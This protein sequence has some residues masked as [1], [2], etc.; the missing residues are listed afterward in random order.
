MI[1][2]HRH[3][4]PLALAL[5]LAAGC[6]GPTPVA[7]VQLEQLAELR[8]SHEAFVH[9]H[10]DG[11]ERELERFLDDEWLP[12]F[13][14]LSLPSEEERLEMRRL[15]TLMLAER[16]D[17]LARIDEDARW[18][19]A[20]REAVGHSIERTA[21]ESSRE[22]TLL[23]LEVTRRGLDRIYEFRREMLDAVDGER[24]AVLAEL[25]EL[26]AAAE[27]QHLALRAALE[28]SGGIEPDVER[29]AVLRDGLAERRV[30]LDERLAASGRALEVLTCAARTPEEAEAAG[31]AFL[32]A[33]RGE[34]PPEL[35]EP[36]PADE[37]RAILDELEAYAEAMGESRD[38]EAPEPDAADGPEDEAPEPS[39]EDEAPQGER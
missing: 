34:E 13:L 8:G 36:E 25:D 20:L 37:Y 3:G 28:R 11:L 7:D 29:E 19:E 17:L 27:A 5:C 18:S 12:A 10:Y 4:A 15:M 21:A 32:A 16:G 14:D 31:E 35:P 6:Q 22:F 38:E 39:G 1:P 23:M 24:E 30:R 33:M 9:L 2:F 26:Y